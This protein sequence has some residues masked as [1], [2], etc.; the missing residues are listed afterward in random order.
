MMLCA[1]VSVLWEGV[2]N[3]EG[4]DSQELSVLFGRQ[5]VRCE[6]ETI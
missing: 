5:V 6:E 2:V 4:A 3:L 1:N